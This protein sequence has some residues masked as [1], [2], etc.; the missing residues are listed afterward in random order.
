[1]VAPR[2]IAISS[3]VA[4]GLLVKVVR[5]E[6]P[7]VAKTTGVEGTVVQQSRIGKDGSI[8]EPRV[9]GGPPLLQQ[10]AID[11]VKQWID[12]PYVFNGETVEVETTIN[13]VFNLGSSTLM[14]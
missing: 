9:V 14:R 2:K 12:R 3:G 11:A 5:P 7:L 10:A 6:Y 8:S 1:V 4:M 13:V